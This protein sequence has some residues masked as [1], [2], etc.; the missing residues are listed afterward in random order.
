MHAFPLG[1]RTSRRSERLSG[2]TGRWLSASA[3]LLLALMLASCGTGIHTQS[4]E[5]GIVVT[6]CPQPS[7]CLGVSGVSLSSSA[8]GFAATSD[9]G[10]TWSIRPLPNNLPV[11]LLACPTLSH[12]IGTSPSSA[13]AAIS[14][15]PGQDTV[16][17]VVTFDGGATWTTPSP[18]DLEGVGPVS[19]ADSM[20]CVAVLEPSLSRLGELFSTSDGGRSWRL[21]SSPTRTPQDGPFGCPSVSRCYLLTGGYGEPSEPLVRAWVSSNLGRTWIADGV[22]P[23]Q[24]WAEGLDC[25]SPSHCVTYGSTPP[26]VGI[27]ANSGEAY[28]T[29]DGGSTWIHSTIPAH[30]TDIQS[31]YCTK[32]GTCWA[33][34]LTAGNG[35]ILS[36]TDAGAH[37]SVQATTAS[38]EGVAL[39][40][41]T[42]W[43]PGSCLLT[44]GDQQRTFAMNLQDAERVP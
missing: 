30:V 11:A 34:A 37:W 36:S 43:S 19:C 32:K 26:E 25:P 18:T 9:D 23:H 10:A 2:V 8:T 15:T 21:A 5:T 6:A 28:E 13:T 44:T 1:T 33:F 16:N 27:Q 20:R 38:V 42:C 14:S 22:L 29:V 31:M 7:H 17:I 4:G 24:D 41:S 40:P 35:V 3:F 12:C 39:S